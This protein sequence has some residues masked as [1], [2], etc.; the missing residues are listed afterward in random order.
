MRRLSLIVL[1]RAA[2][3]SCH[4]CCAAASPPGQ[5]STRD[6]REAPRVAQDVAVD[7]GR[8]ARAPLFEPHVGG[9]DSRLD[10]VRVELVALVKEVLS[11]RKVAFAVGAAASLH[12]G[13]G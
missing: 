6:L 3:A 9:G 10:E 7:V 1:L 13:V 4:C 5:S 11:A 8:L 2:A 12:Q